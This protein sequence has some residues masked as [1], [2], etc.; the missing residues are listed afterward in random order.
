MPIT[1]KKISG[2]SV[3]SGGQATISF[4]NIPSTYDDLI[5]KISARSTATGNVFMNIEL[6]PNGA[7]TNLSG[8]ILSGNGSATSTITSGSNNLQYATSASGTSSTFS[9][10]EVYI[11]NYAGNTNKTFI[12]DSGVEN[13]ATAGLLGI[14]SGLWTN[15][16]AITSLTLTTSNNFAE[17]STIT[18]YG[19]K[20]S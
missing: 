8:V 17:H 6:A 10:S 18:L 20:K 2:V 19:I 3:G 15:T 7:S 13:N 9:N 12:S 4:T 5:L 14:S 1:Y 16:S 11:I